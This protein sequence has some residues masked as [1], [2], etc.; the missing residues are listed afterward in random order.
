MEKLTD[1]ANGHRDVFS[2]TQWSV[3]LS[4]GETQADAETARG[5]LAHLCQTYWPPLYSY[6][7]GRGYSMHD[8][9]DLTQGFF[10]YF[11]AHQVYKRAERQKGKFRCFLLASFKNFLSDARDRDKALKRGGGRD[12][13]PLDEGRANTA[14]S[15]F[16]THCGR[17]SDVSTEDRLFERSWAETLAT[18]TLERLGASYRSEA[19]ERLF[20]E[21][22][23]FLTVGAAPLP[24]YTALA[25]RL[26][27]TES[28][29]RSHVTR[30]RAQ[31]REVLRAE[32][33]RTVEK[34]A[35][36]DGELRELLRVLTRA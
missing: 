33:R 34:D 14:E 6:A 35:D 8:A 18:T 7:R 4:A 29:L 13:I 5:A 15:L 24:T 32:V 17:D 31:Y 10:L 23:G 36:V 11:I 9:Q 19:K 25:S 20:E 16:Q 22:K 21:L 26:G 28:T 30:L 27:I 1:T 2:V 3:I 12:F